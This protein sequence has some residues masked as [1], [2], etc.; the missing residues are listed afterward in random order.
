MKSTSRLDPIQVA[1]LVVLSEPC[2]SGHTVMQVDGKRFE[3]T[4]SRG[5]EK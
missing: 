5:W 4:D 1:D 3:D 2:S